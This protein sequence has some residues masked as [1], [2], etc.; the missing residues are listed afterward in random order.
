[1]TKDYYGTKR[2]TAWPED[3]VE[4]RNGYAVKYEGGYISWSPRAVFEAAYE[5]VDAMSFSGALVA[6]KAGH[7]VKRPCHY[8]TLSLSASDGQNLHMISPDDIM[9]TDWLIVT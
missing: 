2:V 3:N 4:G 5:P 7:R 6:Y 1:M 9:A 8:F